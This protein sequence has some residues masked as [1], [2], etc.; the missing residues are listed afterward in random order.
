MDDLLCQQFFL[1]PTQ[2]LQRR[3]EILRAF[4]IEHKTMTD[5]A[6][7]FG[8]SHGTVR[9]LVSDFRTQC[10]AGQIPPFFENHNLDVPRL[11]QRRLAPTHPTL[12]TEIS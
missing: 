11:H 3:Y 9:N 2:D 12:P 7:Q 6:Q 1:Q 10:R 4:F 5:I 8:L